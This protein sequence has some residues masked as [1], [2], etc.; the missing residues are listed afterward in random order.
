MEV[1][2]WLH[3][4]RFLLSMKLKGIVEYHTQGV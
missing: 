2:T 4:I 3:I 1:S